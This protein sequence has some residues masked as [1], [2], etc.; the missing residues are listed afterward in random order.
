MGPIKHG[1]VHMKE[2]IFSN[3][4]PKKYLYKLGKKYFYP[5]DYYK[6][7]YT[8]V[9]SGPYFSS[10]KPKKMYI[11]N[12][13]Y[14]YKPFV[15][16]LGETRKK[17]PKP[18]EFFG[19]PPPFALL[20]P[21]EPRLLLTPPVLQGQRGPIPY[22]YY[23]RHA[24]K[25]KQKMR[26]RRLAFNKTLPPLNLICEYCNKPFVLPGMNENNHKQHTV[27]YCSSV[28]ALR[29]KKLKKLWM[30]KWLY[31]FYLNKK[32]HRIKASFKQRK[33][34]KLSEFR[35][36]RVPIHKVYRKF[37]KWCVSDYGHKPA[38]YQ[39]IKEFFLH[40]SISP[41]GKYTYRLKSLRRFLFG[42]ERTH[43][44]SCGQSILHLAVD[45]R[46]C[47]HV[48]Y[49]KY[50]YKSQRPLFSLL[51][52]KSFY[53]AFK[54]HG[55]KRIIFAK[56]RLKKL[57]GMKMRIR[58]RFRLWHYYI[59]SPFVRL[60]R[61]LFFKCYWCRVRLI[62][63]FTQRFCSDGCHNRYKT[64]AK[65][66]APLWFYRHFYTRYDLYKI[67]WRYYPRIKNIIKEFVRSTIKFLKKKLKKSKKPYYIKK[68]RWLTC[69]HCQKEFVW[70]ET[71]KLH[72]YLSPKSYVK[73]FCSADCRILFKE[74][75]VQRLKERNKERNLAAWGTE[76]RPDEETRKNLQRKKNAERHRYKMKTDPGY[77]L[78]KIMRTRTKK[79]MKK[80]R[81]EGS[82]EFYAPLDMLKI[83]GVKDG[84]ELRAHM[85]DQ[86]VDGMT[87]SN[88][89]TGLGKWVCDHH[90]PIKY[91][92]D[93]FDLV[94]SFNIQ[95][96][97]FG[98][99]N[100]K[101]MW[102]LDNAHKSAKLN[103]EPKC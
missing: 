54:R 95:R 56:R 71:I 11:E 79:I 101:P 103:Y 49:H 89:G 84:D 51:V 98:K 97:C 99:E 45:A 39:R 94:N 42:R 37:I 60:H 5:K 88:H 14:T 8:P 63:M 24:E 68:E 6:K 12:G 19:P 58:I 17:S 55:L 53:H 100:L 69:K 7:Y 91:W 2:N 25:V 22:G 44:L 80:Y 62:G 82:S 35:S 81:I 32:L 18:L 85:E 48:C 30:P 38:I 23:Y 66:W 3:N 50:T 10:G 83:L 90:I 34:W 72:A 92:R 65:R 93:N 70:E 41:E 75:I 67:R 43:C 78:I 46:F 74:A 15:Y 52:G 20:S 21:P 13:K 76:E 1:S 96:K 40:R 87:W 64:Y 47:D 29:S 86:F 77:K 73:N 4:K 26:D 16:T 36:R 61:F 9:K 31:N 57:R 28:C 102:W 27:L 59:T 33:H